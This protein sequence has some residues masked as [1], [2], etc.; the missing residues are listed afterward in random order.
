MQDNRN[1]FNDFTNDNFRGRH[2]NQIRENCPTPQMIFD[3]FGRAY[4]P[5]QELCSIFTAMQGFINGTIFP[6]LNLPYKALSSR[7]AQA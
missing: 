5:F 4:I 2:I 7:E 1:N 3:G 6:E